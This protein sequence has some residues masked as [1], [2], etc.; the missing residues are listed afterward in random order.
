MLES[1][2]K[3]TGI[4]CSVPNFFFSDGPILVRGWA[5]FLQYYGRQT[6]LF[7]CLS[8]L[9]FIQ[10]FSGDWDGMGWLS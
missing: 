2:K 7:F 9:L 3:K 1:Y 10:K 6:G 8:V 5:F 4:A